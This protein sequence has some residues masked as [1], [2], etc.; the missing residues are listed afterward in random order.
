MEPI[1]KNNQ[2]IDS[3]YRIK[4]FLKGIDFVQEYT[5]F[6]N[7]KKL[8]LLKLYNASKI[9]DTSFSGEILFEEEIL[10]LLKGNE[11][12]QNFIKSGEIVKD[13]QKFY[14]LVFDFISGES[15][16]DKIKR[17]GP[18]SPYTALS[19]IANLLE[20]LKAIHEHPKIII[21][22]NINLN[23]VFL[24]YQNDVEIPVLTDF[25]YARYISSKSRS[26]FLN[27]LNPFYIAPEL[28]NGIFTPQSDLFSAGALLY[29]LIVGTPPWYFEMSD[30]KNQSE[31]LIDAIK[32][33]RR[34]KLLF[35][36]ND[37]SILNDDYIKDI[38]L[39]AL[40]LDIDTRFKTADEFIDT[41]KGKIS[42]KSS[43]KNNVAKSFIKKEGEGFSAIA[44]MK[45]LKE[46]LYNDVIRAL[47]ERD[48]F[49][50]Y[51]ITIPNGMLLY[52]PPGCGKTFISERFA[53]EIGFNFIELKPSDIKSKY[54]NETEEQIKNI[55]NEAEKNS[56]TIIFI[57]EFDAIVPNRQ[58][59]LHHMNA[60]AVNEF[61][62][63]MSNCSGRGIFIIAATNLPEQIDPAMLRTG[64]IDRI[65]YVPPP[66]KEARDAMFR[67]YLKKRPVDLAVNYEK[68]AE[69]TK[70]YVSS[71]IKFI[72]DEA[73]REAL[74]KESRIT[75]KILE[76]VIINNP[77]SVN[78]EQLQYYEKIKENFENKKKGTSPKNR[79]GF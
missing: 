29:N 71:D 23:S 74:K 53:E 46:I 24:K 62:A 1:F 20:T 78:A 44:G 22:N 2:E 55:F 58:G 19:I 39:K 16:L 41:I 15:L 11:N 57:D 6:D 28:Y 26:V 37:S 18:Y 14:F 76:N 25:Y 38:I 9:S 7:N 33:K 51:G 17:D 48:L 32:E 31:N 64:R 35:G 3:G 75:Q 42:I 67:I 8:F 65:I 36:M 56:P 61:L 12:I 79:I 21:H 13:K 27:G 52:G 47:N 59:N 50:K 69:N 30:Y 34:E 49:Q 72:V 54:I 66:D 5:V 45:K 10:S 40:S 77:P 68:L 73:S 4:S 70:N 60:S 63:Q 43:A